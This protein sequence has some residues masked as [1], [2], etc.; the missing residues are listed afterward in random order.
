[1]NGELA[2]E[3]PIEALVILV[4]QMHC[5]PNKLTLRHRVTGSG[6]GGFAAPAQYAITDLGGGGECGSGRISK[7][8]HLKTNCG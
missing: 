8:C 6:I 1:M 4:L 5:I 3:Q 7:V 2:G